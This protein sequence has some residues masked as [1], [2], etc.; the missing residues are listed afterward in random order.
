M[1]SPCITIENSGYPDAFSWGDTTIR[2][3]DR[4]Y[5]QYLEVLLRVFIEEL[6]ILSKEIQERFSTL[7]P[8]SKMRLIEAPETYNLLVRRL[9][10][11]KVDVR[12]WIAQSVE[13]EWAI[14]HRD[15]T[16]KPG[17]W[18]A[19]GSFL[20]DKKTEV[21][22]DSQGWIIGGWRENVLLDRKIPIDHHS[23]FAR[24]DMPVA[25]F[26][27]VQYGDPEAF[28]SG[29]ERKAVDKIVKSYEKIRISLPV[30]AD[31][32]SRYAKAIV[33]RRSSHADGV[34]QSAS[35]NAFIGQIVLLNAHA[36]HVD[37]EYMAESLVHESIH[38]LLWRAEILDHFLVDPE[39]EMGTVTSAW[40]G[41]TI[42]YY[43]LLQACFV[44]YGIFNFWN[45]VCNNH[46]VF[47]KKRAG[48]LLERSRRGFLSGEYKR[49]L[50]SNSDNLKRGVL[51]VF[52]D[53]RNR[54]IA[55][56]V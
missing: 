37:H 41:E 43:T 18:S 3:T 11:D 42:Y 39:K 5:E 28:R 7:P 33:I 25:E 21:V 44:W 51:N 40:S 2:L 12:S 49:S 31:F 32:I 6:S 8:E 22:R 24:R 35:R 36:D 55:Q 48:E 50:L 9:R 27:S 45:K 16:C 23:P 56:S 1:D 4:V 53:M 20:F 34:F 54:V 29:D 15:H 47:D 30:A 38:S 14:L 19:D 13:A 10:G 17:T 46:A 26:R 52:E